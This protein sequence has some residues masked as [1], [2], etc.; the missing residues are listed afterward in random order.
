MANATSKGPISG[1]VEARP[2]A[3]ASARGRGSTDPLPGVATPG[4]SAELVNDAVVHG[5]YRIL[6]QP[7]RWAV[8][9][10]YPSRDL[11][12]DEAVVLVLPEISPDQG[13]GF[14]QRAR[15]EVDRTRRLADSSVVALRDCG[16]L[17]EGFPFFVLKRVQGNSLLRFV[18]AQ[19]P[20]PPD[21]ALHL[22]EFVARS[23]HDAHEQGVVLG[24][25][26]PA[27]IILAERADASGQ[28][29]HEPQIVDM[30]F[31]RGLFDGLL[32]LP[33]SPPSYRSPEQRLGH[34]LS[35][36]DDIYSM[37][38]VLYFILTGK[39]PR[40][41]VLEDANRRPPPAPSNA[42]PEL[43]LSAYIDR[44]V[45]T[46]LAPRKADRYSTLKAFID[47]VAGLRE[48]F[49]LSDAARAMLKLPDGA[50]SGVESRVDAFEADP[51][52]EFGKELMAKLTAVTSGTP[53]P[54]AVPAV[55]TEPPQSAP[56][57]IFAEP[58][59]AGVTQPFDP[60]EVARLLRE[61]ERE[62]TESEAAAT[63]P[64]EALP[65]QASGSE[66]GS[67]PSP[68]PGPSPSP[69]RAMAPVPT[70]PPPQLLPVHARA[71]PPGPPRRTAPLTSVQTQPGARVRG[72]HSLP[73]VHTPARV[74]LRDPAVWNDPQFQENPFSVAPLELSGVGR[75]EPEPTPTPDAGLS[76]SK[77]VLAALAGAVFVLV[78]AWLFWPS[79]A[80]VSVPAVP[81][82]QEYLPSAAPV[83]S[84]LGSLQPPAEPSIPAP[85]VVSAAPTAPSTAPVALSGAAPIAPSAAPVAP[86]AAAPSPPS[87]AGAPGSAATEAAADPS[88]V[89]FKLV[90]V[91][92]GARVVRTRTGEV[93]CAATPCDVDYPRSRTSVV[94]R[95]RFEV[96]G[97][98]P[99][100]GHVALDVDRTYWFTLGQPR[101]DDA[102]ETA[103]DSPPEA[104]SA[105][106]KGSRPEAPPLVPDDAAP[107][108]APVS[109]SAKVETPA[110]VAATPTQAPASAPTPATAP[111]FVNPF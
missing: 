32:N 87:T 78:G 60:L 100:F 9:N 42:R 11:Q 69:L 79:A 97:S 27:N 59:G 94:A 67:P 43:N 19:G 110:P 83:T 104:A 22:I 39:A 54:V 81:A 34:P 63:M 64:Y 5:R 20:L 73:M 40:P 72:T 57:R 31:A 29:T 82:A 76:L 47:A 62:E 10:A 18:T 38:A 103:E 68:A 66:V 4:Q 7:N 13:P 77:L 16:L 98:R 88:R 56:R 71:Q 50:A 75:F 17:T 12:T 106:A 109:A 111:L 14:L 37:G 26:R 35:P 1:T 2:R 30:G 99:E 92:P 41:Q 53:G 90:T 102:P 96:P 8:G 89:R 86:S 101:A 23:V 28:K 48:L 105:A 46:A 24:D 3:S 80:P 93:L 107:A 25:L 44:V 33:E 36:A 55:V 91:P 58:S 74:D 6:K 85:P 49:S 21:S 95:I 108:A 51:T 15:V 52:Q 65:P 70:P 45:Q 61:R 84:G